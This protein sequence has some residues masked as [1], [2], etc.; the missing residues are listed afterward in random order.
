MHLASRGKIEKTGDISALQSPLKLFYTTVKARSSSQ[1]ASKA[2]AI[3]SQMS[4]YF[5]MMLFVAFYIHSPS[6]SHMASL[7]SRVARKKVSSHK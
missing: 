3:S 6:F 4:R 2:G 1:N 5:I 7:C